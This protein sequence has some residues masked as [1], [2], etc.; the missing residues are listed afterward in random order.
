VPMSCLQVT[1]RSVAMVAVKVSLMSTPAARPADLR[2]G[3]LRQLSIGAL[4]RLTGKRPSAIRYYEQVG[5][6]PPAERV[7]GRRSYDQAAARTLAVIETGQRAGLSLNEIKVLVSAAP[8]DPAA[9]DK[10]R[11]VADRKLPEIIAQ[12]QRS[13]LVRDWLECAARCECPNLDDC[14]LFDD[15]DLPPVSRPTDQDS[16][17]AGR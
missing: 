1:D 12:I 16:R 7:S 13:E 5:L 17:S 10:L 2:Q 6:L 11:E 14:P 8:G 15:P 9:I 3:D 4:A